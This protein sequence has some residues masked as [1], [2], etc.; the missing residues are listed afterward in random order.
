MDEQLKSRV[1]GI[2]GKP[3]LGMT[4]D[5]RAVGQMSKFSM[6]GTAVLRSIMMDFT[7]EDIVR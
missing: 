2:G 3:F 4:D 7:S 1:N 5:E 6:I